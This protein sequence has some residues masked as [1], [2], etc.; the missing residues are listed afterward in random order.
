M[1]K[2]KIVVSSCLLG[3]KTRYDGS[4]KNLVG[5]A[6][7]LYEQYD[8][9]HFCPEAEAGLGIPR[10][11]IELVDMGEA[12]IR[13]MGTETR[14]DVTDKLRIVCEQMLAKLEGEEIAFFLLKA[15]SPSCGICSKLHDYEGNE[16]GFAPGLWAQMLITKYG[17]DKILTEE[18]I[19]SHL[20]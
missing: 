4:D 13:V 6:D 20:S 18:S 8:V 5:G 1:K 3:Y 17:A 7:T 9:I 10:E 12:G 11:T 2:S 15:R 16:I 14:T 19:L